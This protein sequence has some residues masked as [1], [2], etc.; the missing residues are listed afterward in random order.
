MASQAACRA[1]VCISR[2]APA[3]DH[4]NKT[5]LAAG[6]RQRERE[7]ARSQEEE[8]TEEERKARDTRDERRRKTEGERHTAPAASLMAQAALTIALS[9]AVFLLTVS[10]SLR[11]LFPSLLTLP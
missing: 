9:V 5:T 2:A 8:K 7:D 11:F 6:D 3:A 10:L 1:S 4:S